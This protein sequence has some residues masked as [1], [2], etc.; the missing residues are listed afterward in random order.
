MT[1][2]TWSQKEQEKI[3]RKP[4]ANS[5]TSGQ[6]WNLASKQFTW[7][8][9]NWLQG[10]CESATQCATKEPA[11]E[12]ICTKIQNLVFGNCPTISAEACSLLGAKPQGQ[13]GWWSK[14]TNKQTPIMSKN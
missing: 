5:Y 6:T 13:Q 7:K 3:L 1:A 10:Y 4:I 14:Q 11:R 9:P 2:W 12:F 8:G